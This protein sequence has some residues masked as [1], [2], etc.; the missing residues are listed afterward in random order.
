M[1]VRDR[2]CICCEP[3][4][5]AKSKMAF[6]RKK[7]GGPNVKFYESVETIAQFDT[8]RTWLYKNCKKVSF[9]F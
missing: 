1:K 7:D 6:H 9:N 3:S 2:K 8:V 4:H 5:A